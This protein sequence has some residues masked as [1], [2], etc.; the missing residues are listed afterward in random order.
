[1]HTNNNE[2]VQNDNTNIVEWSSGI[3]T[4][5]L[6]TTMDTNSKSMRNDSYNHVKSM[7]RNKN[8]TIQNDNTNI[9]EKSSGIRTIYLGTTKDTNSK[10]TRNDS[11]NHANKALLMNEE[12][13]IQNPLETSLQISNST[14]S[15]SVGITK[16]LFHLSKPTTM[17]LTLTLIKGVL[18]AILF[19]FRVQ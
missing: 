1:M 10:S 8:E 12:Q 16:V 14:G 19:Q 2:T 15:V 9:A 11:Y 17:H 13:R 7:H 18:Y 4:I 5:S 6:G 3:R